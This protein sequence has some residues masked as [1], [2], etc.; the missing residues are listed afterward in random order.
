MDI[1]KENEIKL[2]CES[3][4]FTYVDS[5]HKAQII[6]NKKGFLITFIE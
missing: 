2:L 1:N 3:L 6:Q 5:S 4:N